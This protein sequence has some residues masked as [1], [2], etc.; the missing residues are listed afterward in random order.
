MLEEEH[1]PTAMQLI[2]VAHK[3]ASHCSPWRYR[4]ANHL[5]PAMGGE[6]RRC[7][8]R[9]RA[10]VVAD[11]HRAI[12]AAECVVQRVGVAAERGG[13]ICT[14]VR[15]RGWRIAAHERRHCMKTCIGER[16]QQVSPGMSRVGEPVQ[17]QCEWCIAITAFEECEVDCI[18]IDRSRHN[19][20]GHRQTVPE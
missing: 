17:A 20:F 18:G 14:V 3:G 16:G 7:V 12:I 19:R 8:C 2:E 4:H 10:P 15:D 9:R 5:A 6:Y 13:L 1:V 11:D